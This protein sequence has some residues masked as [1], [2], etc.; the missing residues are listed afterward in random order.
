MN[1]EVHALSPSE[2]PEGMAELIAISRQPEVQ[3]LELTEEDVAHHAR[4]WGA[5]MPD[6][7]GKLVGYIAET[8]SYRGGTIIEIGGLVVHQDYRGNG[9]ARALISAATADT[10]EYPDVQ[11]IAFCNGLSTPLFQAEEYKLAHSGCI[12]AEAYDFCADCRKKPTYKKCCDLVLYYPVYKNEA[13]V[14]E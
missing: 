1:Y 14:Y 11:P 2:L 12:P 3:M 6:Q 4:R 5:F 8:R 13:R 9:I 10:L 7:N